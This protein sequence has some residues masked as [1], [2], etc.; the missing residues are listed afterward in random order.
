MAPKLGKEI[1]RAAPFSR[2]RELCF[3]VHVAKIQRDKGLADSLHFSNYIFFFF[4]LFFF[5]LSQVG[6]SRFKIPFTKLSSGIP[7]RLLPPL[8]SKEQIAPGP[9]LSLCP[10]DPS[11]LQALL[12]RRHHVGCGNV[13][14]AISVG[15]LIPGV[16][17]DGQRIATQAQMAPVG[18]D[19][20]LN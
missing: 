4:F 15:G 18:K 14:L 10:Q 5:S 11:W 3:P 16:G 6:I 8:P 2:Q 9:C 17:L 20:E 1:L 19:H 13:L 7:P 12:G